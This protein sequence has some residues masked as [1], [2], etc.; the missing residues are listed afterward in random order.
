LLGGVIGIADLL[1]IVVSFALGLSRK[2][3]EQSHPENH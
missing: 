2:R 1:G 3:A